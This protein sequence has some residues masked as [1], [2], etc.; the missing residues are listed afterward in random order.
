QLAPQGAQLV[1]VYDRGELVTN[2][3][4]TVSRTLLEGLIIVTLV[5]FF[6]LGDVR[7]ALLTALTIPLSLLF[8][9]IC[10][11]VAGIPANLLSLGALDF[12]IIVDGTLVMVEHIV[13]RLAGDAGRRR[14]VLEAV[15]RAALEIERPIFFSLV[16]LICAYLPLF[17]M[18]RVEYRLFGP[19]AFTVCSALLGTL[20]LSLT[21]TPVL[22]SYWFGRSARAWENPVVAW[23]R[24]A[25][26]AA[27]T[28]TLARPRLTVAVATVVVLGGLGVGSRLGLEF[29]PQLDEGVIWIRANLPPGVSLTESA[30][31]ASRMRA[32]IREFPEVSLVI[33]QSGR[34]DDGT[35][36]FGP[37]RNELL[38]NLH[39]YETWTSGRTKAQL[40]AEMSR[41]LESAIPGATFN[42]TQ[43]IIDTSTEMATGSS[44]DLAIIIR[45]PDLKQLRELAKQA[46]SVTRQIPGAA[47]TSIE[48]EA[49][50]PQLR[51]RVN[52]EEVARY[53]INVADV[54]DLIELAVGGRPVGV[55]FEGERRFD[56]VVRYT[57]DARANAAAIG[58]LL[59]PTADG[60]R[61]PL[62]QL[63]DIAV[64][65]GASIIARRENQRQITV[66]T[67]IRGR[68]QGGFVS[69][70]Q[71][72]FAKQVVLPE[73]YSV[74]WGGQFE[75]LTRARARLTIVLP[76]TLVL[77]FGLLFLTFGRA[78]DA[79]IVLASVPFA[80]VGG[81]VALWLR[82]INLSVSAAVGFISLF[83]VA[84]MS[85]V[86]IV[87]EI[88]RLREAEGL[89]VNEAI[90][91]GA[92]NQ[93]RPVLMMLVV[94]LLGMIPAA[95]AVGIGSDVQRPLATVVVGGLFS[96]LI[97]TLLALPSLYAVVAGD[98]AAPVVEEP[99]TTSPT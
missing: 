53:G 30:R 98:K 16:I 68:D 73:G 54:Q 10:L 71:A 38:I 22:A 20:L 46:L 35:D 96:A 3:L 31:A 65:E 75:N 99:P 57:P 84:V 44:A 11:K 17:T 6:F 93:M 85:G 58:K 94:A 74:E 86:L 70:A 39:P 83:G 14:S 12:G 26:G 79:A 89:A 61:V 82:D 56:I 36:P 51:L 81:L 2:T 32:I 76:V 55:V 48:Q 62:S 33:S 37:N 24:R 64:V 15:R 59:A 28:V 66:R 95:R 40:V 7:A 41:R 43:P 45:G 87:S 21:L 9:F 88:N 63:A 19:M 8:A 23:L 34:N 90:F 27:L 91:T 97:L 4:R 1:T 78:R 13:H 49:D 50:Q 67:N 18:E 77:I 52:R 80:L 92:R 72:A 25:Y 60:G 47:D 69:E 42:F 5:L 29:L